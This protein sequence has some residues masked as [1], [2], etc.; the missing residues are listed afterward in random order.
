MFGNTT[1]ND[2]A[3]LIYNATAIANLADNA[4]TSPLTNIA[5]ALHTADP[6]EA[7]TMSTNEVAYTGYARVSVARTAGGWTV[8]NNSVSPTANIDFGQ[9]TDAGS[10]VVATHFTTGFTGGGAAKVINRGVI[11]AVA[12]PFTAVVSGNAFTIPGHTLA[13]NDRICFYP[14]EG[15]SLPGGV[16]EGAVLFVISVTGDVVTVSTTQG[17]ASITVSA[18]GDGIAYRVSPITINLNSIPRLTT[19]TAITID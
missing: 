5:V 19:A 11:G 2:L 17:G 16:T 9:R 13:V 6:G 1:E 14:T 18:A 12:G 7:G 10:A 8:T 15:S 3:R 4:A